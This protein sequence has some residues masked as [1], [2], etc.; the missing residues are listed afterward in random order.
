MPSSW[1]SFMLS[2]NRGAL[3]SCERQKWYSDSSRC[4]GSRTKVNSFS[5]RRG[6][7]AS[8]S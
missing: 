2:L 1:A 5:W 3:G 8:E 7:K 4:M 6:M